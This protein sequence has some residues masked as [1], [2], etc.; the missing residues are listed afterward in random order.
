V[1][2]V[3]FVGLGNMGGAMAAN[4]ANAGHDVVVFDVREAAIDAVIEQAP[5]A[6]AAS[7]LA[8]V[9]EHADVI[10]VVVVDDAQVDAVTVGDGGLVAP[11][12][13]GA[14]IAV[15]STVHPATVQ[16]AAAAAG[17]AGRGVA[18]LDAPI[19]GGVQ[20][21]RD[22]TLCIM[23][24]GDAAA[25][26]RA[27]PVF[28]SAGTLV[29]HLGDVGAGLA[30]KLARNLIGYITLL[31]AA[32]GRRLATA[33]GVDLET[34]NLI[35]DHTGT[36]SPMMRDFVATRGGH[37]VYAADLAPLVAIG[38]KDMRVTLEVA[39]EL[40]LDLEVSRATATHIAEAFGVEPSVGEA[41]EKAGP[42]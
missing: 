2:R 16:R 37:G 5:G 10:G 38:E 33:A 17:R 32:E 39:A 35:L 34:L 42:A 9:A 8:D 11:A 30:A 4:I 40:G 15:H 23:V 25:F 14:V 13:P 31:A 36:L 12:R 7:S 1:T 22:A 29:L 19:S 21:A 27:R 26:E 3:G 18:V 24:G 6:R 20:G 28:E 41:D